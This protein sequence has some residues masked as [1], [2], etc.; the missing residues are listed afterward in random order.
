MVRNIQNLK[1]K[2]RIQELNKDRA[3]KIKKKDINERQKKS[4]IITTNNI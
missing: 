1:L 3:I 4:H 2:K